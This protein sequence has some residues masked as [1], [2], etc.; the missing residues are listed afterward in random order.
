MAELDE[1]CNI[2]MQWHMQYA[3]LVGFKR[4]N[5]HCIVSHRCKQDK[6]LAYWV[7]T[8]RTN[9]NKNKIRLDRKKILDELGFVWSVE[10]A[11]K[12][13]K[14]WHLQYEKLVD[15]K[16]KNGHCNV[17][18]SYEQDESLGR[19]VK[20]QRKCHTNN[21]MRQDRMDFLDKLKFVWKVEIVDS[22]HWS[23]EGADSKEK[24][25]HLHYAKLVE[26]ERKNGHCMVPSRY[27]QDKTLGSWVAK[28][29]GYHNINKMRQHRKELLD[30]I[31]FAWKSKGIILNNNKL[32]LSNSSTL[33]KQWCQQY[34]NL[35]EF[36]RKT[37][38][39]IVLL[40]YYAQD[41]ALANWVRKQR[42]NHNKNK[43]RQD[44]KERLDELGFVWK[45]EG[46]VNNDKQWR[47]QY[48]K[49]VDFKG[50][51]GHCIVPARYEQDE[52]LRQWISKQRSVDNKNKMRQ[53]RKDLL[54]TLEF[55]WG[56]DTLAARSS[57]VDDVSGLVIGSFHA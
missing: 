24:Q 12:N 7:A 38:H 29:R 31:G 30:K 39:C 2:N 26:F 45:Y 52:A 9:H 40:K 23:F 25:W 18:A 1:K 41:K 53:D 33:D 50:K 5:G 20:R 13:D 47:L 43:M 54:D 34:E 27:E 36:K 16:R 6:V 14:Q 35:V 19:W 3:N 57:T 42:T 15:F 32:D 51:T 44:R 56:A 28:Q 4:D 46:V 37:G 48:E 8:Q 21:K 17:P 11:D 10:I 49:L 55:V 22:N